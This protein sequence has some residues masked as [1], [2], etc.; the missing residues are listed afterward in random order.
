MKTSVRIGALAGL[1]AVLLVPS[2]AR[3]VVICAYD[4]VK[5][6][7]EVDGDE[8]I[9]I[10]RA[11]AV[12]HV[13]GLPCTDGP[14][15][16]TVT[17]TDLIKVDLQGANT[18]I[19][20]EQGP[21]APGFTNEPGASDEIEISL[22]TGPMGVV[23]QLGSDHIVAGPEGINL[24]AA[25]SGDDVDVAG[26][27]RIIHIDG[28]DGNDV[29]SARGGSGTGREVPMGI[30]FNGGAGN[31]TLLASRTRALIDDGSFGNA[32]DGNSGNDQIEA[33]PYDDILSGGNDDDV[34]VARGKPG[35]SHDG[36]SGTD[37]VSFTSAPGPVEVN[38]NLGTFNG[39]FSILQIE[40]VT[41]SRFADDLVGDFD[42]NVLRGGDGAD[43]LNGG[44][45]VD[46]GFGGAGNDFFATHMLGETV[47]GGSGSDSV[48]I[49][50]SVNTVNLTAGTATGPGGTDTLTSIEN[51][52]AEGASSLIGTEGPNA[53]TLTHGEG[54]VLG[55]GGND[56]LV[57]GPDGETLSGEGGNDVL[58]G[59]SGG[60][61]M[62]GGPG[63]DSLQVGE[64]DD[65]VLVGGAGRDR[66]DFS[67]VPVPLTLDLADTAPQ[68]T[69]VGNNTL[70]EIED[71][72]GTQMADTIRGTN[73]AN[74]LLGRLGDDLI[75]G[76]GGS[77]TI[78]GDQGEDDL[79]GGAGVD[80][81]SFAGAG[82]G[83]RADIAVSTAQDTNVGY[84]RLRQFENI[85]GSAF[86][87][88]LFG[89]SGANTLLGGN[90]NDRLV[91]RSGNDGL[92]G[93]PGT[94][95][96]DGG[97]GADKLL[98]C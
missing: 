10:S 16:G 53:L 92:N 47:D 54:N 65:N 25:E 22:A 57:G 97:P 39:V 96:C 38:L 55:R 91:G 34:L 40:N 8:G 69:G 15:S 81:L 94:D 46:Q 61:T 87:D 11:G 86:A 27:S 48:D 2:P 83:V 44:G 66:A 43:R 26:I 7:I 29:I 50:D 4:S 60:G 30:G 74:I 6:V 35:D 51:A 82:G 12:I 5:H 3:A 67:Q 63:N 88:M 33:G 32:M 42:V 19:E 31:D 36:G 71:A 95:S 13:N 52:T 68:N 93:G 78:M 17:N 37:T 49:Q 90:G 23:G 72:V 28:N 41:G 14:T 77:D 20:L 45:G 84:D 85:M 79:L 98:S 76:R 62:N 1:I 58:M 56:V 64:D 75:D 73:G 9:T 21:L 59:G 18:R 89:N 70:S 24:N 80:T